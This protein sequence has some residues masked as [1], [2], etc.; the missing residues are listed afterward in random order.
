MTKDLS[1]EEVFGNFPQ[2]INCCMQVLDAV[3]EDIG[4]DAAEAR[5]LGAGFG[6]GM[7]LGSTCGCVTGA[8]MALGYKYGNSE[9]GEKEKIA[10]YNEKKKAFLAAFKEQFGS[11]CCVDM[12]GGLNPA[13]PEDKAKIAEQGLMHD[14]CAN[15][16]CA[17]ADILAELL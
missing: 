15:A 5:R 13:V 9:P 10:A 2:G 16:V 12:L 3:A 4:L 11:T 8:L 7:G 17:A 6:G 14:V 1:A